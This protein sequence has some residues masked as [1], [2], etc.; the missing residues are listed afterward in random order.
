MFFTLIP[1]TPLI[2]FTGYDRTSRSRPA[3]PAELSASTGLMQ[4]ASDEVVVH[5]DEAATLCCC[6]PF[7]RRRSSE[8]HEPLTAGADDPAAAPPGPELLSPRSRQ[9]G[10]VVEEVVLTERTY[11]ADLELLATHFM[12]LLRTQIA[13]SGVSDLPDCGSLV[14]MHREVL[15]AAGPKRKLKAWEGKKNP[16]EGERRGIALIWG[17][18]KLKMQTEGYFIHPK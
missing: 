3:A 5:N 11:V 12:P 14:H 7:F 15:T 8:L 4:G 6:L 1:V 9:L 18:V 16:T 13:A 17:A 10:K 2:A